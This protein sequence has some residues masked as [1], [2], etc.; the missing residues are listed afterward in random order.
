MLRFCSHG[1]AVPTSLEA[2][3][4]Q[5]RPSSMVQVAFVVRCGI[6]GLWISH[7]IVELQGGRLWASDN[8]PRGASFFFTLPI[9]A[10]AQ[11]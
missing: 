10:E 3:Y 1:A 9:K 4:D 6:T 2:K 7:S 11:E 8:V 5:F